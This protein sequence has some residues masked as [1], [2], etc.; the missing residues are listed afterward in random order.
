MIVRGGIGCAGDTSEAR[1]GAQNT[2]NRQ[3]DFR[4]ESNLTA[5]GPE[6]SVRIQ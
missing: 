1:F 2:E 4:W 3:V 5:N 6:D